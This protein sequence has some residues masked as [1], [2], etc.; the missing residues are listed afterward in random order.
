MKFLLSSS[1]LILFILIPA[2]ASGSVVVNEVA[3]MGTT[4]SANDEWVELYSTDGADFTD[5]HL[6]TQD[7]AMDIALSGS[8]LAG[9]YFLIE[10]TDDT[11]VPSITADVV[12]P[13]GSGLSNSGEVLI[14]KNSSGIE[15]DRMDA[16]GGW[17][18]GDNTTKE[19]MQK[20]PS[21]WITGSATPKT[22][23]VSAG[24]DDSS[25]QSS[26]DSDS[27]QENK[28]DE[29]YVQPEDLPRIKVDA[30]SDQSAAVGE[31]IQF[32][33]HA[34]GLDNKALENARYVWNFG[35]GATY[36]GQNVGHVYMFPG[37]YIARLVVSSGKYSAWNDVQVMVTENAMFISEVMPGEAGWIEFQNAGDKPI[38]LGGWIIQTNHVRFDIPLGTTLAPNSF[39]VLS[40]A[41]TRIVLEASGD[42][43]NLFYPNGTY[44]SGFS[45]TFAVPQNKSASNNSGV[46]VFTEPT[47][48]SSNKLEAVSLPVIS[49]GSVLPQNVKQQPQPVVLE[50]KE[51]AMEASAPKPNRIDPILQSAALADTSLFSKT[52]REMVWFGGSLIAGGLA[53]VG[54][55][56]FRRRRSSV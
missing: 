54:V 41:T 25:S 26:S 36:E 2:F 17:P 48:G 56:L 46:S 38:H 30:G 23:N 14:L 34:W 19:T 45:Y 40:A 35:D 13:F 29:P 22:A 9:G 47:P 27:G 7:G 6:V 1:F 49:K 3:W 33:P 43:V 20:S 28:V 15:I 32:R 16:S 39:A 24:S 44:A 50:T 10:R 4:N 21:G 11:T 53:A 8:V 55:V 52:N 12:A 51:L 37:T 18:A 31:Q 42:R 5:W